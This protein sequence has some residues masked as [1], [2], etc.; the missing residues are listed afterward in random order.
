VPAQTFTHYNSAN[1]D[2][3][4]NMV[5]SLAFDSENNLWI[6]GQKDAA[7][8]I[9]NVSKLS[10]DYSTW[11]VYGQSDLALDNLEDRVFYLAI[12]NQ[13]NKWLCTHYGVAVLKADGSAEEVGF[14]VD[15]Y[16]RSVQ[17]DSK[18][19]V[20]ISDRD[21]A[22]IYVSTDHGANWN[23]WSATDIGMTS[24]GRPEV[25]DLCE[26]S[27]DQLW[28]CTWYG[29]V[30]RDTEGAWH[31]I[32]E[33]A[34]DYSY[35]MTIDKNDNKWIAMLVYD[36]GD[37][38][39]H[40]M[41]IDASGAITTIDSTAIP[42][43]KDI[44]WD[45][46]ADQNGHVWCA[47][48]G[49]G[50]V[51]IMPDGSFETH[52]VASTDGGL[53]QDSYTDIEISGQSIWAAYADSGLVR[54]DGA[55]IPGTAIDEEPAYET[56]KQFAI[57][58]NYHNPFNPSTTIGFDLNR[59]GN[60]DITVYDLQGRRVAVLTNQHY[61]AGRYELV[62]NGRDMAGRAVASGIYLYTLRTE[63][64]NLTRKMMFIQ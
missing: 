47:T 19:N 60:V 56:P 46:E 24:G 12:D 50:L 16:T 31:E 10:A 64:G 18:G 28:I 17:T 9:A 45:L 22:G 2:L 20:Y 54:I 3:P 4:Y 25:Y 62:W 44:I 41:K 15:H 61:Q 42:A 34:G 51:E 39:G 7:S 49:S 30:Y 63:S 40:L 57:H 58:Q 29:V 14:T 36:G 53:L 8:G 35:A 13:D 26:D 59:P 5:Y 37:M 11:T 52:T 43:F 33:I 27:Q 6:G 48:G 32:S 21:D 38:P 23:M 1:S 55:I